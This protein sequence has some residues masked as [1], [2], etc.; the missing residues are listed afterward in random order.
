MY[1]SLKRLFWLFW[2]PLP[3]LQIQ[4]SLSAIRR[5]LDSISDLSLVYVH[6]PLLLNFFLRYPEL[7]GRFGHRIL[8]LWLSCED[9]SHTESEDTDKRLSA[10]FSDSLN[11][12]NSLLCMLKGNPSALLV[13]LV[14]NIFLKNQYKITL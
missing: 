4:A 2:F 12:F 11:N 9:Y 14:C 1:Q 8:H 3:T 6:H 7:M 5:I 13:L 10:G